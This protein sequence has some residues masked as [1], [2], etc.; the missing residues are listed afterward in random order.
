M[1][2]TVK[3]SRRR[4]LQVL[5]GTAGALI[6]GIR[7]ARAASALVPP[8]MLG[9][10]LYDFGMFVRVDA[11]GT[12]LI[13]SRDPETGTGVAT[14]LARIIADEMDAD[15]QRVRVLPLGLGVASDNGK[16]HWL[17][18]QQA[19]GTGNS[20]PRAWRDLRSAGALA[21]WLLIRAAVPQLGVPP[22]QLRTEKG[23]VIAPG[24]RR[25]GYGELAAAAAK[26]AL[27]PGSLLL[28]TPDHY[29]LIGKPAGDAEARAIVTGQTEYAL[30]KHFGDTLVA[31]LAHCPW[32]DGQLSGLDSSAALAIKGVVKVIELKPDPHLPPGETVIAPAVAVIAENTWIALQGRRALKLQWK[33]GASG[34]ESSAALEQQATALINSDAAPTTRL[35]DDG[36]IDKAKRKA[37]RR[38]EAIYYQPWLA[39]A[40]NEPMNCLVRLD[41]TSAT[42]Y[43]PTQS[44]QQAWTVVQRLTG[45]APDQIDIR[46]P[47]IGGGY[48]RRLDHDYVAEAVLLAKEVDKP[49]RLFWTRDEDLTHDFYRS[50][51]VHKFQAIIEAKRQVLAWN[52]RVAS[53]SALAG[54][55]VPVDHLWSSEVSVNQFPAGFVPNYRSDWFGL[56]SSMPR[57]PHRGMP[58]ITNAF[59]VD[60][61]I[62]EIAHSLKEDPLVTNLRLIGEPRLIPQQGG[63][64]VDT[65]RLINVLKLA[66]DR[67]G[68]KDWLHSVNG[69]GLACWY[70]DGAYVAHAIEVS[71]QGEKLTIERAV[72][73][74]DV[75]RVINPMGL[76]GQVAG[77]TLDA[78]STALNLAITVKDGKVQQNSWKDY[79]L[80]SMAQLPRTVEVIT[81]PGEGDPAGASFLAMPTAAPALANAVFR[82]SAVRVR[83]LPLMKE[84]LRL[85]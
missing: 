31:V 47:R 21:R 57:G 62:D 68:W 61:F 80:A 60:S 39:H 33:P 44:P 27:P 46:V 9:D 70:M 4:F 65:A 49:L 75:G 19:G 69:L 6:V 38:V 8:D 59:A 73:A 32:P 72:C 5:A 63:G 54:R 85:L 29:N 37:A 15:W 1:S 14:A 71:M 17:Y 34:S 58:H 53:A 79:P 13:G 35:R 26:V 28:K 42:L 56:S 83:R 10:A 2:G 76:E 48:G 24:G 36:D 51:C 3:L 67:I 45:L 64:A 20:M 16:P 7:S 55:G 82:V 40:T 52:Q 74:V 78:L 12:V 18:G 25:L 43:V 30:D 41:K 66:T 23:F 81:V 77:A 22:E 50:G 11:D 84:L